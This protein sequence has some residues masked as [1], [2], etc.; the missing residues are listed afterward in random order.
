MTVSSSL[1]VETPGE[2]DVVVTR[3][4]N[5]PQALV[6]R[7][8]T[9]PELVRRWM[10][11]YPGWT[12]PLCEIDF[13][14]GGGYHYRWRN[15]DSGMEFGFVGTFRSIEPETRITNLERPEDVDMP[16]AEIE[17]LFEPL[18]DMTRLKMVIRYPDAA[19]RKAALDTGMTDGMGVTFDL[20]DG[21]LAE[22][23]G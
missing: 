17:V 20:L 21:V 14:V 18:G 16:A 11:G 5:A 6:W 9:E 19:S 1:T 8:Y 7:A 12:M 4:F 23:A 3:R 22:L 15:D 13:R 2:T 10:V